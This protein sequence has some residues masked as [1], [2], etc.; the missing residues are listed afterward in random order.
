MI[1]VRLMKRRGRKYWECQWIDPLTERLRTLSTRTAR[2]R[3]AERF[4]GKLQSDLNEGKYS[5]IVKTPWAHVA[6]KYES[7]VLA[8]KATG[9]LQKWLSTRH[10][11][12]A[13]LNPVSAASV[14]A[15][16][17]GELTRK[18]RETKIAE[19]SIKSYLAM[20]RAMLRWAAKVQLIPTA[21][22]VEMPTRTG[23]SKGRPISESEFKRMLDVVPK[24]VGNENAEQWKFLLRFLWTSGLRLGEALN[25]TWGTGPIAVIMAG[26]FP[27]LC[28][29]A[30]AD[31]SGKPRLLP[32]APEAAELLAGIPEEKRVGRLLRLPMLYTP[33]LVRMDSVSKV[34]SQI[35]QDAGVIVA[36]SPDGAVKYA[37]AHD[38][39]RS[40]G[41]RWASRVLPQQLQEMMR[42]RSISTTLL[43]YV[44]DQ[45]A[46]IESAMYSAVAKIANTS[47]NTSGETAV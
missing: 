20:L 22:H 44:G 28:I 41:A 45:A 12:E 34:V 16:R 4:A 47:A 5:K 32:L 24:T 9:T 31:K 26:D 39:R 36:K 18:L 27:R 10:K 25:T 11:V 17:I 46:A 42:H 14:T 8:G 29:E 2:K 21:P 38:L 30:L 19:A 7:D 37:S 35:G 15:D 3:D 40:F 23:G 33:D 1:T 43:F 6:D 13:Y